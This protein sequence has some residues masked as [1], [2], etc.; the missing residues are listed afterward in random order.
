[1]ALPTT[2][3]GNLTVTRLMLGGNPISGFSHAGS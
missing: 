1:M 3:L 2:R